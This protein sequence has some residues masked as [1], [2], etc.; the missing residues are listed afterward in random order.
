MSVFTPHMFLAVCLYVITP[1]P[2]MSADQSVSIPPR[3]YFFHVWLVFWT[4]IL[5][6][7][8]LA[9]FVPLC[10]CDLNISAPGWI[11]VSTGLYAV[12]SHFSHSSLCVL[13][14]VI[15]FLSLE[16]YCEGT[17]TQTMR[18]LNS[19]KKTYVS[20]SDIVTLTL[21]PLNVFVSI[22]SWFSFY[23]CCCCLETSPCL[24]AQDGLN[25]L[26]SSDWPWNCGH[27]PVP[28]LQMLRLQ[29]YGPTPSCPC[30]IVLS[31]LSFL[32][33]CLLCHGVSIFVSLWLFFCMGSMSLVACLLLFNGYSCSFTYSANIF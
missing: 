31:S 24:I 27:I 33:L 10:L 8:F 9:I 2:P 7:V 21:C 30:F 4:V 20:V 15:L 16:S 26:C 3:F 28:V 17:V 13:P 19:S 29:A 18:T 6:S 32:L 23:C 14:K 1:S 25:S 12:M 11:S 5:T 22:C